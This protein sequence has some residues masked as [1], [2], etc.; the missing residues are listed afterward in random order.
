MWCLLHVYTKKKLKRLEKIEVEQ[1]LNGLSFYY[2]A[3]LQ[4][5]DFPDYLK[6]I[7]FVL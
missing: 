6:V 2:G 4:D 5:S 1:G 3:Q 7:V